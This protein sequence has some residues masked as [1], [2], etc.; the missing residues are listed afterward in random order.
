MKSPLQEAYQFVR[1]A[2]I[3]I[4][5]RNNVHEYAK[6]N[7]KEFPLAIIGSGQEVTSFNKSSGQG[8]VIQDISIYSDNFR[9]RG[10]LDSLATDLKNE[11]I[12]T[13]NL[14][15]YTV[16][17]NNISSVYRVDESTKTPLPCINLT[18]EFRYI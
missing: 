18:V 4:M 14:E 16:F 15:N 17:I 6:K 11:L 3:K 5:G 8:I 10:T 12:K 2:S 9:N 1:S 13:N 7:Y